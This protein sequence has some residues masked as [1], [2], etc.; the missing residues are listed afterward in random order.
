MLSALL[1]MIF[2]GVWAFFP[3]LAV[4]Y[5]SPQSALVYVVAGAA[6]V[7]V[8]V[9]VLIKF[10]IEH[11]PKGI[12]YALLTGIAGMTGTFFFFSAAQ[13]GKIAIVVGVTALYPLITVLLAV[14]FL[15][16]PLTRKQI[17][18]LL[19]AGG[20]IFLLST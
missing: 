8:V 18:G 20:A 16:E 13:S 5:M 12:V 1:A 17:I 6:L 14:I 4:S 2:Y 10:H 19:L 7:G 3:K 15:H 9:L 11:H